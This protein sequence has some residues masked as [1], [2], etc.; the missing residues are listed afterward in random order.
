MN[1]KWYV[2]ILRYIPIYKNIKGNYVP[3][4]CTSMY[5]NHW[6]IWIS[7]VKRSQ[8]V[9]YV[10]FTSIN[11]ISSIYTYKRVSIHP[12]IVK[13]NYV[14]GL[15]IVLYCYWYISIGVESSLKVA[16]VGGHRLLS[17]TSNRFSSRWTNVHMGTKKFEF[18]L[19]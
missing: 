4:T 2:Y 19:P 6:Y 5:I 12:H 15:C 11:I 7:C 13:V 17:K 8:K 18:S 1:T 10:Q 16:F 14:S 9:S 3:G